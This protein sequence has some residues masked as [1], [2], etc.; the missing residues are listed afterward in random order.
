MQ[1]EK[2]RE[3]E[4]GSCCQMYVEVKR[5]RELRISRWRV[6]REEE[7]SVVVVEGESEES[8]KMAKKT[9]S[10][11]IRELW[12]KMEDEGAVSDDSGWVAMIAGG[13]EAWLHLLAVTGELPHSS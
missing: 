8:G 2:E 4:K 9:V 6:W 13:S 11:G 12:E 1:E 5:E 3:R 10:S 7:I